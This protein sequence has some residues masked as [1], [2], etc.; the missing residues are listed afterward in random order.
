MN[1]DISISFA[2]LCVVLGAWV[3]NTLATMWVESM[4]DEPQ[5]VVYYHAEVL[6]AAPNLADPFQRQVAEW[7]H[8]LKDWPPP[9]PGRGN[10]YPVAKQL[11]KRIVE[12]GRMAI[13]IVTDPTP[14]DDIKHAMVMYDSDSNG[15][16]DSVIDNGYSTKHIPLPSSGLREGKFG[17]YL[18]QCVEDASKTACYIGNAY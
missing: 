8:S 9:A 12:T 2:L 5:L 1:R 17:E 18:G 4:P 7:S 6:K 10:C 13:I 15:G 3:A 14:D 11:Q 16:F